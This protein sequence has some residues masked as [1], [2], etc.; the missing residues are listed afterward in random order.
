MKKLLVL[1][2]IVLLANLAGAESNPPG[3]NWRNPRGPVGGPGWG[4]HWG[5]NDNNPP[6]RWGGRGTNWEN[7]P[8]RRGGPGWGRNWRDNDNNPPGRLGGRGTNWENR[9]GRR[10]GPGASPDRPWRCR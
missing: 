4:N 5:D 6:G 8:G 7:P 2:G 10:G 3:T 1:M 9:P